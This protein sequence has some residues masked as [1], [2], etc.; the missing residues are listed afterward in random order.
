MLLFP[1]K[2][3]NTPNP[4]SSSSPPNSTAHSEP[5]HQTHGSR[6]KLNM[7]FRLDARFSQF[8]RIRYNII[9]KD[10]RTPHIQK[11]RR[12]PTQILCSVR[13]CINTHYFLPT[14]ILE[15]RDPPEEIR[16]PSIHGGRSSLLGR[17]GGHAAVEHRVDEQLSG[18]L[19][20]ASITIKQDYARC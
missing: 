19:W 3:R 18:W 4:S 15:E 16:L 9:S 8:S 6:A 20:T 12:Q 14:R 10:L 13:S 5:P 1:V 17:G 2:V 7:Q 11:R